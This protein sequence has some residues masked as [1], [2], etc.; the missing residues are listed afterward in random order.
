MKKSLIYLTAFSFMTLS[1]PALA[2]DLYGVETSVYTELGNWYNDPNLSEGPVTLTLRADSNGDF[3]VS[4]VD[5]MQFEKRYDVDYLGGSQVTLRALGA[6]YE[7][8]HESIGQHGAIQYG[9]LVI[10]K[11]FM[12][13]DGVT[14][15]LT[16]T[17]KLYDTWSIH[18]FNEDDSRGLGRSYSRIY[19]KESFDLDVEAKG[20]IHFRIGEARVK[21]YAYY[22]I[23]D[24]R[25]FETEDDKFNYSYQKDEYGAGIEY[26]PSEK[27]NHTFGFK[28]KKRKFKEKYTGGNNDLDEAQFMLT[29]EY[30]F[31][32]SS[33]FGLRKTNFYDGYA[34]SINQ[35][36]K[37][38][39]EVDD[40]DLPEFY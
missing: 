26:R 37:E 27:S 34:E 18:G 13:D 2:N 28:F 30:R 23:G 20:E 4:E 11:A 29:Y 10:K 19:N 24:E 5:W 38:I 9:D 22:E 8:I 33:F 16:G 7:K 32:T 1:V 12:L 6:R 25:N 35:R 36:E 39:E 17:A 15:I 3:N 14:L 40:L 31:D 21:A